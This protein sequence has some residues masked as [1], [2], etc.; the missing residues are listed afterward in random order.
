MLQR[1][2]FRAGHTL[3]SWQQYLRSS[4]S[5]WK[6]SLSL[7]SHIPKLLALGVSTCPSR[8]V[9]LSSWAVEAIDKRHRALIWS[10]TG[11]VTGGSCPVTWGMACRPR[12]LGG[13]GITDLR[14]AGVAFR[15]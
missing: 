8:V 7:T 4:I 9:C 5:G 1:M 6:N 12:E 13:L 15:V 3:R 14:R 11:S 2:H 10:S